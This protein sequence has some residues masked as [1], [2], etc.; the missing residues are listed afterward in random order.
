MVKFFMVESGEWGY[1]PVLSVFSATHQ[2]DN[3]ELLR[4]KNQAIIKSNAEC[5]HPYR[6]LGKNPILQDIPV[7]IFLWVS[8]VHKKSL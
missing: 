8:K 7:L 4:K 3:R 5:F 6:A 1:G 2:L